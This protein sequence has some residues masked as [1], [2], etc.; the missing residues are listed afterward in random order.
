M[1]ISEIQSRPVGDSAV[2]WERA[3]RQLAQFGRDLRARAP[4]HSLLILSGVT[5]TAVFLGAAW[6]VAP[7]SS[8]AA[9]AAPPVSQASQVRCDQ[10]VWPHMDDTCLRRQNV[11]HSD[12]QVRVISLDRDAPTTVPLPKAGQAGSKSPKAAPKTSSD[13]RSRDRQPR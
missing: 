8:D 2:A 3:G 6:S 9:A 5:A 13:G 4:R 12:R 7:P 1:T 11:G 10:Q